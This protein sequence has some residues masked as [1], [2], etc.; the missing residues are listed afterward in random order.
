MNSE[1]SSFF[2][3]DARDYLN[4]YGILK[5][6]A[7]HLGLRSKLLVELLFALECSLKSLIY[8]ESKE[9]EKKTYHKIFTHNIDKLVQLLSKT[10]KKEYSKLITIDLSNFIVGIRYQL[11]SEI[12]FRTEDGILG[13]KYYST[14]ANFIWLD[15]VSIQISNFISYIDNLN[16]LRLEIIN[17][18]DI[19]F[20][21]EIEKHKIFRNLRIK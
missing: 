9:D 12:D 10:S 7:T 18:S 21:E 2:L 14:I 13:K 4:R 8:L 19:N 11:E 16:P 6:N 20:S 15:K 5:K 17:F 3:S 1:F